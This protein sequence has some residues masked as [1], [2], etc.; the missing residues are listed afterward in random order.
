MTHMAQDGGRVT[1]TCSGVM[2]T[3]A[4]AKPGAMPSPTAGRIS[5]GALTTGFRSDATVKAGRRVALLIN[6]KWGEGG[7]AVTN[8]L[9]DADYWRMREKLRWAEALLRS[10]AER[11]HLG[12]ALRNEIERCQESKVRQYRIDLQQYEAAHPDAASAIP[13]TH[14]AGNQ[15]TTEEE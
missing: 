6:G 9:T 3:A 2:T 10:L 5:G 4:S 14:G 12:S 13:P 7:F 8:A 11:P 15:A 1:A